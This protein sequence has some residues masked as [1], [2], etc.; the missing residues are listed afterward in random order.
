LPD[1]SYALSLPD[2]L[3]EVNRAATGEDVLPA[4]RAIIT[5]FSRVLTSTASSIAGGSMLG[6]L[7]NGDFTRLNVSF[8]ILN[9]STGRYMDEAS[10]RA[11]VASMQRVLDENP[12]G[13]KAVIWGDL[14]RVLSF[15]EALRRSLFLSMAVSIVSVLILTVFVFRSFLHGLYSLVPL[16]ASLFLNFTMMAVIGIPLDMT[17]IMV[18]NIAI[19]VGV[20]NAIYLVIQYRRQLALRPRD[21]LEALQRTLAMVGQPVL[22]SG[23]SIVVGLSVFATAEFLPVMYFGVL[24]LFTLLATTAGTLIVLPSLLSVDTRVRIRRAGRRGASPLSP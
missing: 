11:L 22:L 2:L 12:V 23:L 1:V 16:G 20:D 18:S 7:V 9:A 6:N 5:M 17:T 13:G 10:F 21:P 19:G 24:V 8:R 15:A 14:L 4:N 3:R